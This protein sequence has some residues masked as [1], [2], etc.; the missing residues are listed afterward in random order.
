MATPAGCSRARLRLASAMTL[1][2]VFSQVR[3]WSTIAARAAAPSLVRKAGSRTRDSMVCP[4]EVV[5]VSL[6]T[7]EMKVGASFMWFGRS[8][9]IK[10]ISCA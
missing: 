4:K 9:A 3:P 5:E 1:R 8:P 2:A 7:P 6:P 10:Q